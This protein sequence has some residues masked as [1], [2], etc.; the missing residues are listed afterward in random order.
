MSK[1]KL[2]I[3]AVDISKEYIVYKNVQDRFFKTIFN[4]KNLNTFKALDSISFEVEEGE[5]VGFLGRN[6]AG[7]STLLK[8]ITGVLQPTK[9][10]VTSSGVIASL[11]EL[12]AGFNPDMTGIENIYLNGTLLGLSRKEI[13]EKIGSIIDFADIGDF[14]T[15]P[16]KHYSSGMFARLAFSVAINVEPDILIIDEVLSVGD[17]RFQQKSLRKLKGFKERNKTI[18]FVSHDIGAVRSFCDRAIWIE[19]GK[20]K[21][22]GDVDD[23]TK[24]YVSYMEYGEVSVPIKPND[25]TLN[26]KKT[27]VFCPEYVT[28]SEYNKIN[29][30]NVE[31][32]GNGKVVID[33]YLLKDCNG[34]AVNTTKGGERIT[35]SLKLSKAKEN[36][37]KVIVGFILKNKLGQHVLGTNS[38]CLESDIIDFNILEGESK[39]IDISFTMPYLQNGEYTI[40]PAIAVGEQDNHEQMDWIHDLCVIN[41][42]TGLVDQFNSYIFSSKNCN[43]NIK[44]R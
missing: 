22:E 3:A 44:I 10:K 8:I 43:V 25:F 32:F 35:L 31:R 36:L 30:L 7:K 28:K 19:D 5:C 12:G 39:V 15:Q 26:N 14:I 38:L 37:E 11:L 6:G 33:S 17:I 21:L 24:Q 41:N 40:S 27:D 1:K 18:L 23:V 42:H 29:D 13:D 4:S 16:V 34:S 20:I 9:G 2:S